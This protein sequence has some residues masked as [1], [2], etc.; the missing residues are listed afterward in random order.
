MMVDEVQDLTPATINL[1]LSITKENLVFSGDTAQTIAKGVGFRFCDLETLFYEAELAK[2][3]IFQ[4]TMNF[5]THNQILEMANS[6]VALLETLFPQT[7]DKMGK[8]ISNLNGPKPK[9]IV[10][11]DHVDLFKILFGF[12]NQAKNTEVQ[13]GCN[14]VI[15]VRTQEAKEKLHP[16][17]SHALCLTVFEAKGLEF[18]DVVLY[19]FFTD[20]E[21]SADK[22][23]NTQQYQAAR[24]SRQI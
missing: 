17:L 22:W 10:S 9:I 1:L 7:I 11:E 6:I 2:P 5:R 4:L 16:L 21:V 8:E 14:Q 24:L 3:K 15:I 13:F 18:D 20:S 19:N 12:E 23:K